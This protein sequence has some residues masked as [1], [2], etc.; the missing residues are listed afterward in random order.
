MQG[1]VDAVNLA[2]S[3]SSNLSVWGLFLQADLIVKAVML[4]LLLASFWSWAIIFDKVLKLRRLGT[5]ANSFEETFWSGG[6]IDD[7]YDRVG[8]RPTDPMAA[9]F[10]AAM[11]EWRRSVARGATTGAGGFQAS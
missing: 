3:V 2:G 5:D 7:L 9:T 4:L 1:T 11:R 6:S 10:A 8:S